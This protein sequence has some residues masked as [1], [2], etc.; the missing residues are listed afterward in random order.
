MAQ[1]FKKS[2]FSKSHIDYKY[3]ELNKLGLEE[4]NVFIDPKNAHLTKEQKL[5]LKRELMFK[6]DEVRKEI[7]EIKR[8][9]SASYISPLTTILSGRSKEELN[10]AE[11]IIKNDL[12]YPYKSDKV[13][14]FL[15]FGVSLNQIVL[16]L[17]TRKETQVTLS[18]VE[19]ISKNNNGLLSNGQKV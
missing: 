8:Q 10:I 7:M 9:Q 1:E 12:E 17:N 5:E 15:K 19:Q 4:S 14:G 11:E 13:K 6:K 18:Y 3:D 16:A 2:N